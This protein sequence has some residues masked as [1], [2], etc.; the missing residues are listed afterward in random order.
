MYDLEGLLLLVFND[1]LQLIFF[2]FVASKSFDNA[3]KI[4]LSRLESEVRNKYKSFG[5]TLDSEP[6]FDN[7]TFSLQKLQDVDQ[8]VRQRFVLILL[9]LFCCL[10]EVSS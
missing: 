9:N 3:L 4:N 6:K 7:G 5:P 8:N 1:Y 10:K 2:F